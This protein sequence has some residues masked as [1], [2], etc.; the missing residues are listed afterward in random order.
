MKVKCGLNHYHDNNQEA[1][2]CD[3]KR[4]QAR[5]EFDAAAIAW[6]KWCRD[7]VASGYWH[8]WAETILSRA[9]TLGLIH[10]E[11]K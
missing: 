9:D 2:D 8:G 1:N 7:R 11:R 4:E 3:K 10:E 5:K 6:A